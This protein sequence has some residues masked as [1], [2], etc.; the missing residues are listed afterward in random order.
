MNDKNTSIKKYRPVTPS[1][2]HRSILKTN[3]KR[4]RIKNISFNHKYH[5][6]RNNSGR[7]TVRHSG[8]RHKRIYRSIDFK[9]KI[10][11]YSL[12]LAN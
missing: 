6:G 12:V 1:L 4:L 8:G 3:K 10:G 2:R 9:R 11:E 5:A 7:I